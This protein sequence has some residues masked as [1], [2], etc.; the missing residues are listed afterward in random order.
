MAR[1]TTY[2]DWETY[3]KVLLKCERL[4]ISPY[5]FVKMAIIQALKNCDFEEK[6]WENV[7]E[8]ESRLKALT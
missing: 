8:R 3:R 4:N 5:K 6:T 7:R 2:V 1:I